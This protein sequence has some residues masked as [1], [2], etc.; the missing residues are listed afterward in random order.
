LTD[1]ELLAQV[2]LAAP[3]MT[4]PRHLRARLL[5]HLAAD[6]YTVVHSQDGAWV[7]FAAPGVYRRVLSEGTFLLKLDP[8]ATL[9]AHPH[10]HMERCYVL[11]GDMYD[12]V[13]SLA[14]GDF[15]VRYPGSVHAPVSTRGGAIV[16]IIGEK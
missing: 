3:A 2:A 11:E 5:D 4:P 13:H 9:P 16:L 10:P 12:S 15:E 1:E 6:D 7:P 14:A 8:G